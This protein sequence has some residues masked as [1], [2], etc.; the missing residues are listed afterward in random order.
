MIFNSIEFA[1]FIPS[2]FIIYWFV[3]NKH[4]E[5]QNLVIVCASYFFYAWWDWRFLALI[6]FGTVVDYFVGL[7]LSREEN[8]LRRKILLLT[9]I[10]VNLGFLGFFKYWNFFV[11]N[12]NTAFIFLGK[13]TNLNHLNIILP[14]GISFYTFRK[15]TYTIDIFRKK[16]NPTKDFMAFAAFVSFFPHLMAGP[17][18]RAANMLPQFYTKRI[19]N[20]NRAVDGLRQILWGL[21]KKVVIA[22]RCAIIANQIFNNSSDYSG[23]T[24]LLGALFYTFQIYGDFSGYSDIAIGTSSLFG[25]KSRMNF[26]FPYFSR[27]IAEFWR[28]WHISLTTWFRDYLYI[29]LGGSRCGTFAKIRNVFIV[30]IVSGFWHGANWT[31][32]IW[33]ALHAVYFLP[34]LL[35]NKNR[36]HLEIVAQ[37]RR[38]PTLKEFF[39]IATTFGLT[40]LAWIFFRAENLG[41]ALRYISGVFSKSL[42]TVPHFSGMGGEAITACFLVVFF[43][44]EWTGRE[45]QHALARFGFH[46]PCAIRWSIYYGIIISIFAYGPAV[47]QEFIYFKF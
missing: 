1:I 24:L 36:S 28:R 42:F 9:S 29:P 3:V 35:L 30:F 46:M 34:L 17:I 39:S 12:L 13:E 18:E 7:R 22:D 19:F 25:F 11:E 20:Y 44:I 2:V 14:I 40:V 27:D 23:S 10:L 32:I 41:H 33:G 37:G 31:F 6:F 5:F 15:L 8:K 16:T 26:A 4:L 43:A 45:Q 47:E 38:F 21:F